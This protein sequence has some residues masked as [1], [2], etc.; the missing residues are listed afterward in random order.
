[1]KIKVKIARSL[2]DKVFGLIDQRNT[3]PLLFYTRFGLHTFFLHQPIDVLVLSTDLTIQKI[4]ENLLP[5][6]FFFYNPKFKL[7]LEL[8]KGFI[9]FNKL[10]LGDKISFIS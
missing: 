1:M 3:L 9:K 2:W 6:S 8:P 10:T 4:K 5:N 7:V